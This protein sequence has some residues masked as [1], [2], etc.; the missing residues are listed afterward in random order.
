MWSTQNIDLVEATDSSS[1]FEQY[2]THGR[3]IRILKI[4]FLRKYIHFAKLLKPVLTDESSEL[5]SNEYA[6]LRNEELMNVFLA[7]VSS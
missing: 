6:K 3:S 2:E 1:I 7:R 5:I 4:D